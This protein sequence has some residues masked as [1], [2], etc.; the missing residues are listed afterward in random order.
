M[1]DTEKL[2]TISRLKTILEAYGTTP[3]RW[4]EEERAAAT[5]LIESSAEAHILLEEAEGFGDGVAHSQTSAV[6]H[7]HG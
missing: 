3:E 4:P 5:A 7:M 1:L 2:V 6:L